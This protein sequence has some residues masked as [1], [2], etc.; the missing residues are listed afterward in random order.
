MIGDRLLIRK[1]HIL[2][3]N[4]LLPVISK[5]INKEKFII[6]IGGESGTGKSEI[7][8]LLQEKLYPEKRVKLIHVDDYYFS[9][10]KERNKVRK[11]EGLNSVGKNEIDWKKL[12]SILSSFKQKD[13]LL[14]VQRIHKYTDSIEQVVVK[15]QNIDIIILE[16]LYSCYYKEADLKIYLEG[17]IKDTYF[18]RKE[19]AKENPDDE[20]RQK[21]MEKER[22]SI[23]Q[24]KRFSD[25]II[26]WKGEIK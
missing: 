16:G 26:S 13:E 11:K 19:R 2:I 12:D 8:S 17:S 18:F 9:N 21:V 23:V 5:K 7:A 20:F 25:I 1:R 6:T 4:N 24:S 15:N 22:E 14:F 10:W 3:V